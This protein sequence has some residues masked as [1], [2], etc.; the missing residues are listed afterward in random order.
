[1]ELLDHIKVGVFAK[2]RVPDKSRRREL[3]QPEDQKQ[4]RH[5]HQT[6][7]DWLVKVHTA[8]C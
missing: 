3:E 6:C 5:D 4:E 8:D 7:A 2:E 1:M